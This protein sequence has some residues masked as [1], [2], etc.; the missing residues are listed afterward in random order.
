[1]IAHG[2]RNANPVI[3]WEFGMNASGQ[4]A[5]FQINKDLEIPSIPLVL[6]KI[7][8]TL[9]EDTSS[10]K[11]LE[12]LILHDPALSARILRLANSAFYSFRARVKTI[13]HAI[14]LLGMNVVTS[15]AIGINIF[16]TFTKGAH[17]EAALINQLWTHSCAVAVLAK[18]IWGRF[19]FRTKEAEFAFLCGLLHDL[20]KVVLFKTYPGH[21]G[22]IFA[23]EKKE[24]DMA[25]SSYE[26]DNYGA[27]HAIIGEMVA[28]K[29]GFPKDLAAV[30]RKHHDTAEAGNPLVGTV[31]LADL[32]AKELKIGYD[33]DD[34]LHARA[35]LPGILLNLSIHEA[36]WDRLKEFASKECVNIKRFFQV[37]P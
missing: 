1:L 21:Y 26:D 17:S 10:A 32:L 3:L 28:K 8:Q 18:K 13:S 31:M 33:G 20:G 29:W 16:D 6:V 2:G 19:T 24:E 4:P 15:L 9:D 25:I 22:S 37:S 7:I 36:E 30:I 34:G 23:A 35:D 12:D 5:A 27:D 11:E 14:T